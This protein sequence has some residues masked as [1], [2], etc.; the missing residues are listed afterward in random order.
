MVNKHSYKKGGKAIA[1]GG[2]G[3][4][5]SPAL[6]C[7]G[8]INRET[9]KISKLMSEKHANQEYEEI[10]KIKQQVDTIPNYEDYFIL[11]DLTLCKPAKLTP[12]DLVDYSKTCTALPKH[13]ITKKNIN[14]K[15][16]KLLL[17]NIPNG[18]IPVDD[19]IFDNGSFDII[20]ELNDCLMKL[21]KKGI[22]PMNKRN[23]YHCDIKDSNVLVDVTKRNMKTRLI[24]WGL[25]TEYKPFEDN[26][27]PKTWRNRPLQYN[28]PFSVIIFSDAFVDKY[29]KFID[30]GGKP[31]EIGLKPFVI[32]YI[33]FWI[34]E[35]GA[36][37]YKFI[38]EIMYILF[39]NELNTLNDEDIKRVIEND[40]TLSYITN[41]I[42]DILI[43]YTRFRENG[44]LNL[45]EYLDNVFINNVDIWGF[46]MVY[47]PLL[48]ILHNNYNKLNSTEKEM[49]ENLKVLIINLYVTRTEKL[50]INE[51]L[52][53]L[54]ELHQLIK[55]NIHGK[56]SI[57]EK[58]SLASGIKRK[59]S[60]ITG[61]THV[62]KSSKIVFK[63]IPKS[64]TRK[65]KKLFMIESKLK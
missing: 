1:S 8:S 11:N 10:Q 53:Q 65:F 19:Y 23:I 3:C 22:V 46:C 49:F 63:R 62:P 14:D 52:E 2:F 34:K 39:S 24:D 21:L 16:D 29:T 41:Y 56:S 47:F 26:P 44:S 59:T 57:R 43:H 36:G 55:Y 30:D 40:F 20:E 4:V 38:N 15:L 45:R 28:V 31:D 12:S 64:K 48:E 54:N 33:H 13:K 9:G 61:L 32:D 27:F 35:R 60:G 25:A 42:V 58:S 6:K 50:N 51:I 17:L 7:E 37:H 18:G 5:F